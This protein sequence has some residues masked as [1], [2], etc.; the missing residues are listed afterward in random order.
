MKK[1]TYYNYGIQF[2]KS[3]FDFRNKE[4]NTGLYINYMLS[5]T[6]NMFEWKGLPSTM[7]QRDLELLLQVNGYCGIVEHEGKLYAMRGGLGGEPNP[8][9]MPTELIVA[10]PSLDFSA[11]LKIDKD[12]VIIPS[13]SMYTGFL[14]MFRRY[15][16]QL[17]ENDI[18]LQMVNILSRM[19]VILSA[20]DDRTKKSSEEFVKKI[21][22][23]DLSVIAESEFI[24]GL[25]SGLSVDRSTQ[26]STRFTDYIELQQYIKASWFNEIGLNANYNMKRESINS[27]EAQLN[28]DSLTPLV[29]DMLLQRKNGCEKINMMFGTNVSVDL[30]PTWQRVKDKQVVEIPDT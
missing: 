19:Q 30:S 5:R 6:I 26:N 15:A 10:N 1:G 13:D 11:S 28:G 3:L 23:G 18:S 2:S 25:K 16:S 8:Y 9:Y 22:N 12:C 17:V 7:P 29:D 27:D 21:I 4:E 14:P 20:N 24:E